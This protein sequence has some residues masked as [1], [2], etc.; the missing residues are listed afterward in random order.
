MSHICADCGE[1]HDGSNFY[2]NASG[3]LHIRCKRCFRALVR[4]Q[5]KG[6]QK[7][8]DPMSEWSEVAQRFLAIRFTTE[9]TH[10]N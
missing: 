9:D 5:E 4:S 1:P 8:G 2:R 7:Y 3:T 6:R 10:G